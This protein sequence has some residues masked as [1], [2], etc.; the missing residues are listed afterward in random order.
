MTKI[1]KKIIVKNVFEIVIEEKYI[2]LIFCST[3]NTIARRNTCEL[4]FS[5][6]FCRN[7]KTFYLLQKNLQNTYA[8]VDGFIVPTK[9]ICCAY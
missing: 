2:F 5:L 3:L 4:E 9:D 8:K 1:V 7:C 6:N